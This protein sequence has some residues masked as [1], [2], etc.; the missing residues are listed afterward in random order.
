MLM[1]ISRLLLILSCMQARLPTWPSCGL[2]KRR[3]ER[4]LKWRRVGLNFCFCFFFRAR[5]HE[6]WERAACSV[7]RDRVNEHATTK[8]MQGPTQP[9]QN[10]ELGSGQRAAC[11]AIECTSTRQRRPCRDSH[12]LRRAPFPC[13][14]LRPAGCRRRRRQHAGGMESATRPGGRL[15][16]EVYLV[17]GVLLRFFL[18]T[19]FASG[20]PSG[21]GESFGPAG[22][23]GP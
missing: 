16:G 2:V 23:E 9:S 4:T 20:R 19:F 5:E 6:N 8:T 18:L 1:A 11:P 10:M 21:P 13:F 7:S 3:S 12:C 17:P 14:A 22:P 15:L